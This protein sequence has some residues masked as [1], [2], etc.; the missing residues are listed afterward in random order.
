MGGSGA[1]F[2]LSAADLETMKA[3]WLAC[4]SAIATAGQSYTIGGRTFTRPNLNEVK[5]MIKDINDA[6]DLAAGR[7][8]RRVYPDFSQSR[9]N[10]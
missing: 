3:E 6:I 7:R 8:V 5:D 9:G 4:L 10:T 2:G 1:F